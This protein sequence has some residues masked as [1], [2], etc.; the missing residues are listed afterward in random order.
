MSIEKASNC[1]SRAK[2]ILARALLSELKDL[3][4]LV[5]VIRSCRAKTVANLTPES[6]TAKLVHAWQWPTRTS[7]APVRFG[8]ARAISTLTRFNPPR[9]S[10]DRDLNRV[11]QKVGTVHTSLRG[12]RSYTGALG[13]GTQRRKYRSGKRVT[14]ERP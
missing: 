5:L 6:T 2:R 7:N 14:K 13:W 8:R 4:L 12:L 3:D 11:C 9:Q 10:R 1:R